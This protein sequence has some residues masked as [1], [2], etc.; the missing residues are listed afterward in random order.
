MKGIKLLLLLITLFLFVSCDVEFDEEL[1]TY[2]DNIV[3]RTPLD[4]SLTGDGV[5][6][7]DDTTAINLGH[8][9]G[10]FSAEYTI[11]NNEDVN[12]NL[13]AAEAVTGAFTIAAFEAVTLQQGDSFTFT[14]TYNLVEESINERVNHSYEFTDSDGRTFNFVIWASNRENPLSFYNVP[15]DEET[16]AEEISLI[17]MGNWDDNREFKFVIKN[18][19]LEELTVLNMTSPSADV[20]IDDSSSFILSINEEREITLTYNYNSSAVDTDDAD[21]GTGL[22]V[23]CEYRGFSNISKTMD[24]VA[25]G[26]I[27]LDVI[28]ADSNLVLPADG[29]MLYMGTSDGSSAISGTITIQNNTD[30]AI[31]VSASRSSE[32]TSGITF[33]TL[34][35]SI[36]IEAGGS[37]AVQVSFYPDTDPGYKSRAI[38]L[39]NDSDGRSLVITAWGDYSL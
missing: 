19:G 4:F 25:G 14:I 15:E 13:L 32:G 10:G 29:P 18:E 28:D 23:T 21:D 38:N 22:I 16:E 26:T 36:T 30:E 7:I 37:Y 35:A 3:D 11:T 33:P 2:I 1:R 34:D 39:Y 12:I 6:E 27:D 17:D 31:T 8:P 5:T 9:V 20:T 24:I